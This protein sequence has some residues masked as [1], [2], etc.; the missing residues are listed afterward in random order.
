MGGPGL[1]PAR[2][3]SD[4]CKAAGSPAPR[5]CSS[6]TPTAPD[7]GT[8]GVRGARAPGF[9]SRPVDVPGLLE[10]P[11]G[12]WPVVPLRTLGPG[13]KPLSREVPRCHSNQP[14]GP[15]PAPRGEQDTALTVARGQFR[16]PDPSCASDTQAHGAGRPAACA[17]AQIRGW[18]VLNAENNDVSRYQTQPLPRLLCTWRP[19]LRSTG[20]L[21]PRPIVGAPPDPAGL[22][23]G[24]QALSPIVHGSRI[25]ILT[26]C[27]VQG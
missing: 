7:V 24:L 15:R 21:S 13:R 27:T 8:L 3:A 11:G 19:W 25:V 14:K 6:A 17:Q 5:G 2:P 20:A 16:F 9:A 12:S 1:E 10:G 4:R 18:G 23:P 26:A 22:E